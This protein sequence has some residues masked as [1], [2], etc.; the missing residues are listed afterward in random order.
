MTVKECT[1]RQ[2]F[3]ISK[4]KASNT[5]TFVIFIIIT[6]LL[7]SN[8]DIIRDSV[9]NSVRMCISTILPS[10][11]PFMILSDYLLGNLI[12]NKNTKLGAFFNRCF[13]VNGVGI[14][15]FIIG[16]ICG[17]PLGAKTSIAL[18]NR[19]VITKNECE[20]LIG[21]A[22]NPSLAFIISGV[23]I[24]MRHSIRDGIILYFAVVLSS[25]IS[26]VI[27][28]GDEQHYSNSDEILEQNYSF[29]DSIKN[30]LFAIITVCSYII[31]FSMVTDIIISHIKQQTVSLFLASILEI[32]TA[33]NL[34]AK[35]SITELLSLPLTA[36]A[37]GFSGV[38]VYLQTLSFAPKDINKFRCILIKLLQGILAFVIAAFCNI[39]VL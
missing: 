27:T 30:S 33:T 21:F 5:I 39:I 11:F 16:N 22:N 18:Y 26:G 6:A 12:T 19:G 17:F 32:G 38:S 10:I 7:I 8:H 28:K 14:W 20:R 23:G 15:P 2:V 29:I 3:T 24:G 36:F 37:L 1:R 4:F 35:S 31:F 9:E 34:I 25:C 13:N